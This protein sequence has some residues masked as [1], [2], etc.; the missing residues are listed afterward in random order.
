MAKQVDTANSEITAPDGTEHVPSPQNES[1]GFASQT[2]PCR[3]RR[4]NENPKD[5]QARRAIE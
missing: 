2:G 5:S 4:R 1:E 3:S